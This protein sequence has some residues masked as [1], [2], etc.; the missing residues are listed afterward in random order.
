MMSL[1]DLAKVLP[2][3]YPEERAEAV[4]YLDSAIREFREMRCGRR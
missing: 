3:H 4:D 2:F 1:F